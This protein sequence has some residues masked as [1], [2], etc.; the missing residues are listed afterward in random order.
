MG[1]IYQP[2]NAFCRGLE[3]YVYKDWAFALRK[4]S[5]KK[6]DPKASDL[7]KKSIHVSAN[8]LRDLG[9]LLDAM[10]IAHSYGT[11]LSYF[12]RPNRTPNVE[13]WTDASLTIGIGG[14]SS[15]SLFIQEKWENINLTYPEKRD[16]IWKELAAIHCM[17]FSYAKSVNNKTDI[18]FRLWT[19][20][21]TCKWML[22]HMRSKLYRPDLQILI[23]DICMLLLKLRWFPRIEH[24]PGKQNITADA[25]SRY[26]ENPIEKC[27]KNPKELPCN[28]LLQHTADL[29][30]NIVPKDK[31]LKMKDDDL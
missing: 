6:V 31:Y 5:D 7:L 23:N 13:F 10:K 11:P 15:D 29:C 27:F 25:L 24:I 22:I 16:I 1:T 28:D 18:W 19:D 4:N 14:I 17:L 2:L 30:K 21:M 20:N 8:L 12:T 3:V 26:F 9:T